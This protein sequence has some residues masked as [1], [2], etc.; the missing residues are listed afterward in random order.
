MN[1]AIVIK[2]PN[3]AKKNQT[4]DNDPARNGHGE[5]ELF[6]LLLD[7]ISQG[8]VAHVGLKMGCI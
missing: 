8:Q 1:A 3:T 7:V 2:L 5:G 6:I 4:N